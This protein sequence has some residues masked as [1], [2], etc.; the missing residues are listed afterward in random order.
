[1]KD[2]YEMAKEVTLDLAPF[3]HVQ[4]SM[5]DFPMLVWV[6]NPK[7]GKGQWIGP[8][9]GRGPTERTPKDV[10]SEKMRPLM[11]EEQYKQILAKQMAHEGK[12]EYLPGCWC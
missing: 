1:M 9:S 8:L 7:T 5:T 4:N 11:E 10:G 6:Q 3:V 12:K 2:K